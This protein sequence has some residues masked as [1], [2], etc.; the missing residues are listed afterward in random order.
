MKGKWFFGALMA[1][2]LMVTGVSAGMPRRRSS[3]QFSNPHP[4][5]FSSAPVMAAFCM[6][7]ETDQRQV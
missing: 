4:M 5:T 1:V 2:A 3:L 7:Q 6:S